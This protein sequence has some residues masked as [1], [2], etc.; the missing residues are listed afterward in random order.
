MPFLAG[1]LYPGPFPNFPTPDPATAAAG[2]RW[3]ST[4][5]CPLG[6]YRDGVGGTSCLSCGS[7]AFVHPWL[8]TKC[9]LRPAGSRAPSH[10]EPKPTAT[11]T[12]TGGTSTDTLFP[13][14]AAVAQISGAGGGRDDHPDV[15]AEDEVAGV[16]VQREAGARELSLEGGRLRRQGKPA[17]GRERARQEG[18]VDAGLAEPD[19]G[20]GQARRGVRPV[21]EDRQIPKVD[22]GRRLVLGFGGRGAM[23]AGGWATS[24]APKQR[25]GLA[26]KIGHRDNAPGGIQVAVL[27]QGFAEAGDGRIVGLPHPVS[28]HEKA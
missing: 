25:G 4:G 21:A 2:G 28:M 16:D 12:A 17:K 15:A 20:R 24:C 23:K 9:S 18:V 8:A 19:F 3:W 22:T 7:P 14:V 6:G 13:D 5:L 27:L 26:V 1:H 10:A 11:A